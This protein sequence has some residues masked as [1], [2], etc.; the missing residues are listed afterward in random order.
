MDSRIEY[1]LV[2]MAG[3]E[4]MPGFTSKTILVDDLADMGTSCGIVGNKCFPPKAIQ[5]L[6]KQGIQEVYVMLDPDGCIASMVAHLSPDKAEKWADDYV[7]DEG[8]LRA[9]NCDMGEDWSS[10]ESE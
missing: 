7:S 2:S 1:D 5:F 9:D 3:C 6:K 8:S 10:F 4:G